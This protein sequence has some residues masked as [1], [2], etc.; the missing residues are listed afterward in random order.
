[1]THTVRLDL[2]LILPHIEDDQDECV[3]R[4]VALL[5]ARN[6]IE[7][8][9]VTHGEEDRAH[10]AGKHGVQ[11]GKRHRNSGPPTHAPQKRST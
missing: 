10:D 4:L 9:H 6:G 11:E 3:A 8:V 7:R 1:M 2:P 5:E